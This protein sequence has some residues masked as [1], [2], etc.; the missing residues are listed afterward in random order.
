MNPRCGAEALYSGSLCH[1]NALA[2]HWTDLGWGDDDASAAASVAT[3]FETF[4]A[5]ARLR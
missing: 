3:A 4:N 1:Q 5:G 2:A